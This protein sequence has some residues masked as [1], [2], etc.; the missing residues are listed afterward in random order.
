[1]NLK[2]AVSIFRTVINSV[3]YTSHSQDPQRM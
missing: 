2:H 3:S 1:M